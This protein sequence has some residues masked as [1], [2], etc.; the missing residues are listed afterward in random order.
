[1]ITTRAIRSGKYSRE[2]ESLVSE[3]LE[4]TQ[5]RQLW[6]WIGIAAGVA[7]GAAG[8]AYLFRQ[9]DAGHRMDRLLRRCEDRIKHIQSSLSDLESTLTSSQT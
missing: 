5:S 2:M 7:L 6:V 3:T 8:V 9:G 1:M 4:E